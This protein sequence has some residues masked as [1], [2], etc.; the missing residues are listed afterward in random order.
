[1][2][3]HEALDAA[4][5]QGVEA[6]DA[7]S[8][9]GLQQIEGLLER[10]VERAEFV[11]DE[12]ADGLEA[13]GRGV[14]ARL[15]ARDRAGDHGGEPAGGADRGLGACHA[16]GPRNAPGV[17]FLAVLE[18]HS[19]QLT[20]GHGRE[21]VRRAGARAG[22]HAHVQRP[23]AQE[24]EAARGVVQLRR[25]DAEIEQDAVEAIREAGAARDCSQ[26]GKIALTMCTLGSPMNRLW[27]ARIASGSRSKASS[28]PAS[29]SRSRIAAECPPLP[30]VASR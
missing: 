29:P 4:V 1:V 21:P 22:I 8:P 9:A 24:A 17:A 30:S 26:F 10:P 19:R 20:L 15:A 5:L 12:D 7:Q 23:V 2:S 28:L 25:G 6:D 11:V 14:L 16:D 13:A 3:A 18:Q 27:P